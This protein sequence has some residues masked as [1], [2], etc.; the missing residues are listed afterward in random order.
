MPVATKPAPIAQ[1][2]ACPT[3]PRPL[4]V[5][6]VVD[7]RYPATGG[8][9]MQARLLA[10]SLSQAGH[11]VHVLAPLLDPSSARQEL[12]DGVAVT[13]LAYP[14]WRGLGAVVLNLRFGAW[15]LRRRGDFDV[16][17]I[18][19]V[20]NLAAAA[21]WMRVLSGLRTVAKV[22]GAAEFEGGMLDPALRGRV[23]HRLLNAGARRLDAFQCISR[24]TVQMM[25]DA[26]YPRE[27]LHLLPNAVDV[28]RFVP[29]D[30]AEPSRLRVVFVGR[31]VRVK[32]L[33]VLLHA[34]SRVRVPAHARLV[35]AG[36]GPERAGL[37]R[38][39]QELGIAA[40][41]EFAGVVHDVPGLL[42]GAAM[43]V[44]AS[45]REGLPNAVL[46]AMAAGLPVVATRISGHEDVVSHEQTGLLVDAE[47]AQALADAM[48]QL[49]DDP[50]R[51]ARMGEQA[52][53]M[54]RAAYDVPAVL[55][56][57]CRLYEAESGNQSEKR[58]HGP[59]A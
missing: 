46:E 36:D 24:H 15:L 58:D 45:R 32:A 14:R 40:Q 51:R 3:P 55:Q 7:G 38:L 43:Y 28:G 53:V 11:H 5:L 44:Q 20:H 42:A 21:G 31:H 9:E 29:A 34:W 56:R 25:L 19:M 27:R 48:Q 10:R 30:P 4:R 18:H 26:G 6:M 22:S 49:I 13:R 12:L 50:D 16:A 47:D 23:K 1:P 41:V 37:Q 54:V 17:H 39:A 33:D 59:R 52:R 57:L 8:A 35:L 2:E